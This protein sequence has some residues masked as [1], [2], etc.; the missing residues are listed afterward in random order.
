MHTQK[1]HDQQHPTSKCSLGT[2]TGAKHQQHPEHQEHPVQANQSVQHPQCKM[3]CS[4]HNVR[5]C[6]SP[7]SN[8]PALFCSEGEGVQAVC[9]HNAQSVISLLGVLMVHVTKGQSATR[10]H[11]ESLSVQEEES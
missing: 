10:T 8:V 7:L 4:T 2:Q 6:R 5:A 11:Q 1:H 3:P 9:T